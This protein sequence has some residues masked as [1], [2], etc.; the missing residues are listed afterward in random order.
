MTFK[1]SKMD[2]I[3]LKYWYSSFLGHLRVDGRGFFPQKPILGKVRTC[4]KA[5]HSPCNKQA[6]LMQW[7]HTTRLRMIQMSILLSIRL[8]YLNFASGHRKGANYNNLFQRDH[9]TLKQ[10]LRHKWYNADLRKPTA[11]SGRALHVIS[12]FKI[13]HFFPNNNWPNK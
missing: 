9:L 3:A 10:T 5:C 12:K 13:K 11:I 2:Q 4:T 1:T 6:F 8:I 7:Y